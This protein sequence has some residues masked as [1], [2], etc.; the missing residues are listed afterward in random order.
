MTDKLTLPQRLGVA[1][2]DLLMLLLG[3]FGTLFSFLTAFPL[4]VDET[5]LF[6]SCLL[7]ALGALAVFS[8][9]RLRY[10]LPLVLLWLGGLGWTVWRHFSSLISAALISAEG[11]GAVFVRKLDMGLM[12]P[13]FSEE[14]G[15]LTLA[16][17]QELCTFLCLL[18]LALLALWLGWAVVER[19]SFW[20]AFW[21]TFPIL[22]IPLS[23]T[24]TPLWL[25]LMALILFWAAGLLIRLVHK[26]DPWGTAK[27]TLAALPLTALFLFALGLAL[28]ETAYES[29]EWIPKAR[30]QALEEL[31]D[32]GQAVSIPGGL[33]GIVGSSAEVDLSH[34]G[35]LRYTGG[36]VLRVESEISGHIYL[37][38]F[39]AAK[40]TDRGWE[41]L[42]ES[43]YD[44]MREGWDIEDFSSSQTA[45]VP[46]QRASNQGNSLTLA[47]AGVGGR[48]TG[49]GNAQ[50]MNFPALAD[51]AAHPEASAR[52]FTI[53][54]VGLS[55]GYMY[56]PYQ[57]AT[58]P[59]SMTG[60]E[61]VDDAYL[62]RGTGIRRYVLYAR[63]DTYDG[64]D[65]PATPDLAVESAYR[66]FVYRNY[67]DVP[68]E[69]REV[70]G[71][72]M[73][74]HGISPIYNTITLPV[75]AAQVVASILAQ[76]TEYDPD[77]P[78]TPAGED[79]VAYFL[80]TSKRGYCM[81]YASAA[82][83]LLRSMGVPARYVSGYT[84]DVKANETVTVPDQNAHAWV[85]VYVAGYGW[86]PAEVT[87]GFTPPG[88]ESSAATPSPTPSRTPAPS[89]SEEPRPSRAPNTPVPNMGATEQD[90]AIDYRY[91][92]A[93]ALLLLLSG[94]L[95]ARRKLFLVWRRRRFTAPDVNRAVIAM[96]VYQQ[97]LLRFHEKGAL[98]P[99]AETLGQKAKFSQH[100]LTEEERQEML[101]ATNHFAARTAAL[102]GR[103]RGLILRYLLALI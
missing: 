89:E 75:E 6:R 69:L 4:P 87:P 43:S 60:A 33:T 99:A 21:G 103:G 54:G 97:R 37:R 30:A 84:A 5:A 35:P 70:L 29:A 2:A 63:T 91:L 48:R 17:R 56:T 41:Q 7:A 38:G 22:L 16:E 81:H 93:P 36:A 27:L 73:A 34:A 12:A 1:A 64:Y 77:T 65:R 25:P 42:D 51:Q 90:Q 100:I 9:P 14:L 92:I 83:L 19:Q 58:T 71:Q 57:L 40:Y 79:F 55:S 66:D 32:L 49:I 101:R 52:R 85:E 13:D 44:E 62:A 88:A 28:P 11:V 39:S 18:F 80:T 46:I 74:A 15:A 72:F 94:L 95:A 68:E 96:Y 20:L 78:V 26:A 67:L 50:P 98:D 53:E 86:V 47:I 3:L 102:P 8:V 23:I 24:V 10:R 61:F 59:D 82:T 45:L 31:S 76:E